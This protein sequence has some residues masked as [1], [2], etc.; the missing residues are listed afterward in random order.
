VLLTGVLT[1][2][3]LLEALA[4]STLVPMLEPDRVVDARSGVVGAV[5]RLLDRD[6]RAVVLSALAAFVVLGLASAVVKFVAHRALLR[7]RVRIEETIRNGLVESTLQVRWTDFLT[8]R[9]GD[10]TKA[11]I[12]EGYNIGMGA[13]LLVLAAAAALSSGVFFVAALLISVPLTL[14]TLAFAAAVT[15]VYSQLNR[16]VEEYSR[17][18]ST[19]A[20]EIGNETENLFSTLKFVRSTGTSAAALA[21]AK[22][23][24]RSYGD[25]FLRT[26]LTITLTRLL[27]EGGSLVLVATVLAFSYAST[28]ALA[29]SAIT[30]L[31]I[32]YRLVPRLQSA[33]EQ[34]LQARAQQPWLRTWRHRNEFARAH[35][36][37]PA[38]SRP[39]TFDER[40]ALSRV[41]FQYPAG[42]SPV[43]ESVDLEVG[44]GECIALVGE[45][46]S[47][48]T[49]VLDL[50]SGLLEPTAGD[51]LLD[52]IPLRE[53]DR[54]AWQ[55]RIGL[56]MQEAPLYH[57]TILENIAWG[58]PA[59]DVERV[60]AC[61]A[62]AHALDFIDR[63]PEGLVSHIG[64]RG[65]RLSGGQRQRIALARALYREPLLL[66]L[67]EPTSALDS[68]SEAVV[69]SALAALR[70]R[71]AIVLVAHR[72]VTARFA[73]RVVVLQHGR[74]V[75]VGDF[76][77][78][79]A[80]DGVFARMAAMQ[81]L[82]GARS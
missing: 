31:A 58:D 66:I 21:R 79:L 11:S 32:F 39:P 15:V 33:Q 50:M 29:A 19:T 43:L 23:R 67:D 4:L 18:L 55:Q 34:F 36:D 5:S 75:E 9:I 28:G 13:Q 25:A 20:S 53:V 71:C 62:A 30:F 69:L 54:E 12:D 7:L 57:G 61:A 26:H 80:R 14:L 81:G 27:Y 40:L 16:R 37:T 46:G 41:T 63:S 72:L 82:T 35:A 68:E 8:M 77:S 60:R 64:E 2:S 56:V 47:G 74:A 70:G 6:A 48:K 17:D 1:L 76:N 52:G 59:P 3:A 42:A 38:G 78:L 22:T 65:G 51:V 73:D 44:R 45:S 49:T 24:H 10:I